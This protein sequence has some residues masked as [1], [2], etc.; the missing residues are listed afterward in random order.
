[1]INKHT[2]TK[3]DS[4]DPEAVMSLRGKKTSYKIAHIILEDF[5]A[6]L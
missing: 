2:H 1:M 6:H 5:M 3:S 4:G